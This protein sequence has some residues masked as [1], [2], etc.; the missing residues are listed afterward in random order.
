MTELFFR[1]YNPLEGGGELPETH[2]CPGRP[3]LLQV[4]PHYLWTDPAA[5]LDAVWK[6]LVRGRHKDGAD[7]Q[8]LAS[9]TLY[10]SRDGD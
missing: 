8:D 3:D 10:S 9:E 5:H 2:F 1:A 6:V 7:C 4:V